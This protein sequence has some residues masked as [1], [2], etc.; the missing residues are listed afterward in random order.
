M[1]LIDTD[2]IVDVAVDRQPHSDAAIDLLD[3]I[4]NGFERAS[5]AWHTISNLYYILRPSSGDAAARQFIL[6]ITSYVEVVPTGTEDVSY[7]VRLPMNDFEDAM[8]VAAARACVA[9][10]IVTRNLRDYRYSPIP[11]MSPEQFLT[12]LN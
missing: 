12:S 9:R 7:A 4:Q 1:I 3:R 8:Q 10:T 2:I 6:Q 5:V 11:A